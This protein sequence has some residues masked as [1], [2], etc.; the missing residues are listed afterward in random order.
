MIKQQQPNPGKSF[1]NQQSL[2]AVI[3]IEVKFFKVLVS[4]KFGPQDF[5]KLANYSGRIES[6]F[7]FASQIIELAIKYNHA[8]VLVYF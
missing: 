3:L 8:K 7:A 5:A 4:V 2:L 6:L 1:S